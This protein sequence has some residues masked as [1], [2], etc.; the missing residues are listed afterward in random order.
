MEHRTAHTNL[1]AGYGSALSGVC[2]DGPRS[3]VLALRCQKGL[4]AHGLYPECVLSVS[5]VD[6]GTRVVDSP[7]GILRN[8]LRTTDRVGVGECFPARPWRSADPCD[9]H[10]DRSGGCRGGGPN[11]EMRF[12]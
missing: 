9:L 6:R 1:G 12:L 10:S 11:C 4:E 8:G 2:S 7:A 3:P 5:Q